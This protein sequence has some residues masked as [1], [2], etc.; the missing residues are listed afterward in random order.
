MRTRVNPT[1][2]QA[3]QLPPCPSQ[4]EPLHRSPLL[5][6]SECLSNPVFNLVKM[7][8]SKEKNKTNLPAHSSAQVLN[9]QSVLCSDWGPILTHPWCTP[10][11]DSQWVPIGYL[12]QNYL[13]E[14]SGP[15]GPFAC[16]TTILD[17][18]RDLPCCSCTASSA[19]LGIIFHS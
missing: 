18:S 2:W 9:S 10:I 13:P 3:E 1:W 16:S 19:S 14:E 6:S 7:R 5:P 11:N 4:C 12:Y 8:A 15:L 17:P